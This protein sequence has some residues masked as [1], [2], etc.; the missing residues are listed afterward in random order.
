MINKE[1]FLPKKDADIQWWFCHGYYDLPGQKRNF[2]MFSFFKMLSANKKDKAPGY[3]FIGTH[4]KDKS[5]AH[6]FISVV[7]LKAKD[8]HIKSAKTMS[9]TDLNPYMIDSFVKELSKYGPPESISI[10]DD[11]PEI[12]DKKLDI[13]WK[14]FSLKWHKKYLSI[15]MQIEDGNRLSF[16][17]YPSYE[18]LDITEKSDGDIKNMGYLTYPRMQLEGKEGKEMV[19]GAAWFDHQWGDDGWFIMNKKYLKRFNLPKESL[20]GWE[21]F[22]INLDNG[23]DIVIMSHRLMNNMEAI[24]QSAKIR[25][26]NGKTSVFYNIK[27]TPLRYWESQR[28]HIHYPVDWKI[29]IPGYGTF[30]LKP[31]IDDQEIPFI[32]IMRAIWEGVALVEGTVNEKLIQGRA[33]IELHGYGYV[34]NIHSYMDS[35]IGRIDGSI[36]SFLPKEI[37]NSWLDHF[38]GPEFWKHD[39]KGHNKG[40]IDPAWDLL[41]RGGKHWRPICAKLILEILGVDSRLYEQINASIAE[42]NHGG[43]LIIDDIQDNSIIRR[44]D[45]CI[46]LKYGIDTAINTGNA[47]YFLP[48]LLVANHPHLNDKQRLGVYNIMVKVWTK[49]HLGQGLDIYWSKLLSRNNIEELIL[50][51]LDKKILQMY[52]YKTAAP[53]EGI[54]EMACII[55]NTD[56][57]TKEIYASLGRVFGVAFQII[58]D[59]NNFNTS[60]GWT[61]TCGEDLITGKATY[62]IIMAI[63]LLKGKDQKRL[64]DIL[65]LNKVKKK[66]SYIN[67]GIQLIKKS[68]AISKCRQKAL[69]MIEKE[70]KNFSS[71]TKPSDAKI[72]FRM[73][74]FSLLNYS[75]DT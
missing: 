40:L 25:S 10:L 42:L 61:K 9:Q 66:S 18:H 28:T 59:V 27:I 12:S 52:S 56:E 46:H 47:L 33:R 21:W 26:K 2:F 19:K 43:S 58:D 22:G 17:L 7:N 57:K 41:S 34:F 75:Y 38:I 53:V 70:W 35:F 6:N 4:L 23:T 45:K 55:A 64:M 44:G 62:L 54:H 31:V 67:E 13:K 29:E 32:G 11:I 68:G 15:S 49:A 60:K 65:C 36:E 74:I 37:D 1:I 51:G 73:F 8:R 3:A 24:Y 14:N 63:K 20:L 71:V 50:S 30:I 48:Y 16:K 39:I 72:M 69:K 5:R